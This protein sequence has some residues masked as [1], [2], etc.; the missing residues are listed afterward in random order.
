MQSSLL[1][2]RT[3]IIP[4][5]I[6]IGT[7][8]A[9]SLAVLAEVEFYRNCATAVQ[10][11]FEPRGSSDRVYLDCQNGRCACSN[12]PAIA[13]VPVWNLN[14]NPSSQ[15]CLIDEFGPC[16]RENGLEISCRPE[17]ECIN[18]R[19]RSS[20][21][22]RTHTKGEF[23]KDDIDCE[24]GLK[25]K[26]VAFYFQPQK[27]CINEEEERRARAEKERQ[28]REVVV[29]VSGNVGGEVTRTSIR[30]NVSEKSPAPVVITSEEVQNTT[31]VVKEI[32]PIRN[33]T[34]TNR[35][36]ALED[37]DDD[38]PISIDNKASHV[39]HSLLQLPL[40][41]SVSLS[42]VTFIGFC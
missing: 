16:G 15:D 41:T 23:C 30:I 29:G 1:F 2:G 12:F 14:W 11:V 5:V 36:H 9:C 25:C 7:I 38:G 42:I 39:Q 32:V 4:A 26:T 13:D 31:V 21:R 19:C 34:E 37:D 20:Q 28:D 6:I 8:L 40:F 10:C 35:N 27:S 18:S 22:I 3:G 24:P 33:Q 17:L